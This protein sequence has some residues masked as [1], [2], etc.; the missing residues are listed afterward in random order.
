[1]ATRADAVRAAGNRTV[2]GAIA[3]MLW[4]CLEII[5]EKALPL[6][7]TLNDLVIYQRGGEIA[8]VIAHAAIVW[9]IQ[10]LGAREG[11]VSGA[12]ALGRWALKLWAAAPAIL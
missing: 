9:I 1:M 4:I 5:G 7:A 11:S 2:G 10:C 6:A 8:D 12:A 3:A